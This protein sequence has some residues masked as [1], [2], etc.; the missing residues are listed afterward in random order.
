LRAAFHQVNGKPMALDAAGIASVF[1]SDGA[2]TTAVKAA[3]AAELAPNWR[4]HMATLA[5]G[6]QVKLSA[7]ASV[8]AVA[9]EKLDSPKGS[10]YA[11][12][13]MP[14]YLDGS[15]PGTRELYRGDYKGG[16]DAP[17]QTKDP[18][19]TGGAGTQGTVYI[20]IDPSPGYPTGWAIY[21]CY[22]KP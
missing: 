1:A 17:D 18:L 13:E 16:P 10:P 19:T 22:P 11:T 9:Y 15:K 12:S 2:A 3:L 6:T 5:K 14:K 8:Q 21:T 4:A 7:A 20:I